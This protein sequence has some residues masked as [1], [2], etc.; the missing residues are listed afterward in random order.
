MYYLDG[1]KAEMDELRKVGG[2]LLLQY[3]GQDMS[4]GAVRESLIETYTEVLLPMVSSDAEDVRTY[5]LLDRVFRNHT[6][7]DPEFHRVLKAQ[8]SLDVAA[9][10]DFF[11]RLNSRNPEVDAG[12]LM[13]VLWFL[14]ER[15]LQDGS[16][17]E[18]KQY[19]RAMILEILRKSL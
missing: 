6:Q 7:L 17:A 13:A 11:K 18:H 8:D 3:A 12:H 4:N 9:M 2:Q 1:Y 5:I 15:Y 14:S 19:A 10:A 16:S